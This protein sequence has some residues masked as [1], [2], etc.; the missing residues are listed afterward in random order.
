MTQ[1]T[2]APGAPQNET[3]PGAP[4]NETPGVPNPTNPVASADPAAD[5]PVDV[6]SLPANVQNLINGLR[7]EAASARTKAK[8]AAAEQARAELMQQISQAL[9]L[10]EP[11]ADPEQLSEQLASTQLAEAAARTELDI[12]RTATRLGAD[13]ERLLDSRRFV[14]EVNDLPDEGFQQ[15]L[16]EL[17]RKRLDVDPTLRVGAPPATTRP[18]ETLRSG[19]AP[20]GGDVP[21]DPDTWLRRMRGPR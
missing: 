20:A 16:E 9:G 2:A 15:A 17:I 5:D 19:S 21:I 13:A 6:S 14:Q 7:R 4:Q 8:Q 18:V 1:S 11:A 3:A 10:S 12:F